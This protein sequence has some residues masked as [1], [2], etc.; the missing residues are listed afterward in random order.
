MEK[1]RNYE[2]ANVLL[3]L[4]L[5]CAFASHKRGRW[6]DRLALNTEQHLKKAAL[7]LMLAE[8]A[9][10]DPLVRSAHRYALFPFN[11]HAHSQVHNY[12]H[13]HTHK[14]K[15]SIT[16]PHAHVHTQHTHTHTRTR[17]RTLT[18]THTHVH[19][20]ARSPAHSF[21]SSLTSCRSPVKTSKS[22]CCACTCR[23]HDGDQSQCSSMHRFART[24]KSTSSA[25]C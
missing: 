10:R 7:A 11:S 3:R 23:P 16:Q 20:A 14:H 21:L 1:Q 2:A 22:V 19:L 15:H 9:L 12:M 5:S 6:W 17:T 24:L 25:R 18:H 13:T 8:L 4:L